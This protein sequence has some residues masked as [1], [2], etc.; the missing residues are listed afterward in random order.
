MD[1]RGDDDEK[2][3]DG[4]ENVLLQRARAGLLTG[5]RPD[6]VFATL[7]EG[8]P[9]YRGAALAVC[10]AAG[11]SLAQAR[12]RW[13][14]IDPE[15]ISQVQPDDA[16]ELGFFMEL[17]GFFD[18]H[19]QLDE[20]EQRIRRLFI[21]AGAETGNLPSGYAYGLGRKLQT[22]RLAEA[23]VA[24]ATF[25]ARRQHPMPAEYWTNLLAAAEL[26]AVSG[27]DQFESCVAACRQRLEELS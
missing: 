13:A 21:Q 15:L 7:A 9:D 14:E 23:F 16:A 27:D 19:R 11:V 6:A 3:F 5:A 1:A 18:V 8:A 20:R 22:G 25:G 4:D 10:V 2:A 12:E 24:M 26:L 17:A